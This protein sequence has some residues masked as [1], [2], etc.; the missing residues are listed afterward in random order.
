MTVTERPRPVTRPKSLGP[1]PVR[2]EVRLDEAQA[3]WLDAEARRT[4]YSQGHIMRRLVQERIDEE[5]A[6]STPQAAHRK[7]GAKQ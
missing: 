2:R 4:G 6:S 1:A 5:E 3:S 7:R